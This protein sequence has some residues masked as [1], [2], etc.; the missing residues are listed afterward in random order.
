MR[1]AAS[2][3]PSSCPKRLVSCR[4][5]RESVRFDESVNHEM[6][7]RSN[8]RA[9]A[10]DSAVAG[11]DAAAIRDLNVAMTQMQDMYKKLSTDL[12]AAHRKIEGNSAKIIKLTEENAGLRAEL[13]AARQEIDELGR[14]RDEGAVNILLKVKEKDMHRRCIS[15]R[16]NAKGYEVYISL[17]PPYS[18]RGGWYS[19]KLFVVASQKEVCPINAL[20]TFSLKGKKDKDKCRHT[21]SAVFSIEALKDEICHASVEEFLH[22]DDVES[23]KF[24]RFGHIS[25]EARIVIEH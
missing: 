25:I 17:E 14:V 24:E 16:V 21:G 10:G 12:E 1:S 7:C 9:T 6:L 20:Y 22:S 11:A 4:H 19:L 5:C 8:P 3:H 23:R 18:S 2:E 15:P 13:K